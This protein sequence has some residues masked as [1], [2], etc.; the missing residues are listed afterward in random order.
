M[1]NCEHLHIYGDV[2]FLYLLRLNG[3]TNVLNWTQMFLQW[4]EG[5]FKISQ[6]GNLYINPTCSWL[7]WSIHLKK[8]KNWRNNKDHWTTRGYMC[9]QQKEQSSHLLKITNLGESK[10][11]R[12]ILADPYRLLLMTGCRLPCPL[13]LTTIPLPCWS[14]Q[15]HICL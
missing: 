5:V 11:K 1:Q 6:W 10:W 14:A 15:H 7:I 3:D 9:Q 4:I 2:R 8:K 13:R 12:T